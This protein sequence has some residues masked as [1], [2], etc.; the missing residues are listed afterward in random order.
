MR[1]SRLFFVCVPDDVKIPEGIDLENEGLLTKEM[2]DSAEPDDGF[3]VGDMLFVPTTAKCYV[4]KG[5]DV[6]DNTLFGWE[7]IL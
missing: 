1:E 5:T 3:V 2:I 4:Y 6:S 7:R